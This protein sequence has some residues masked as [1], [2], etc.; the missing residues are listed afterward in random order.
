MVKYR[1]IDGYITKYAIISERKKQLIYL[2]VL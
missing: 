1:Y 2:A